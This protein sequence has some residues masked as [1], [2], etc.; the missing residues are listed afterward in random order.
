MERD[1]ISFELAKKLKEKGYPQHH[2]AFR[3][4]FIGDDKPRIAEVGDVIY[5]TKIE[6][7]E[8]LIACPT[9]SQVLKWLR[10]EKKI[11]VS[12]MLFMFK[13]GWC[14]EIV[15]IWKNPKLIT[16]QRNSCDTYEKAAIAGIE[17]VLNNLI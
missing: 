4:Y 10:E 1:F 2:S 17:Y 15:Q 9:I 16:T 14:Y 8:H 5:R 6:V 7:E 11:Y 12:I 3:S 13:E